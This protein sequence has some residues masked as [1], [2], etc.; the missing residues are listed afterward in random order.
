MR[1]IFVEHNPF[2]MSGWTAINRRQL[3]QQGTTREASR[4][5]TPGGEPPT[6]AFPVPWGPEPQRRETGQKTAISLEEAAILLTALD[7]VLRPLTSEE[8]ASEMAK[9]ACLR[10]LAAG[11]FPI[12]ERLRD[13]LAALVA[14]AVPGST[15]EISHGELTVTQ[16][17]VGCAEAIGRGQAIR[18][19]VTVGGVA[20]GSGALLLLLGVL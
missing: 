4:P 1:N 8:A 13:R 3:G 15:L 7:E 16:K 9:E 17:A 14:A 11:P 20:A 2:G 18:T 12:V 10:E 19:V 5:E 6:G